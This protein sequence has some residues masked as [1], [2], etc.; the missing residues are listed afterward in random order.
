MLFVSMDMNHGQL[1]TRA[2][3]LTTNPMMLAMK[4]SE[5]FPV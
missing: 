1:M 5:L 2:L 3:L 4:L